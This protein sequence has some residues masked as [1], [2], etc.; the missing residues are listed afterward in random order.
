MLRLATHF[1]PLSFS[2]Y[3]GYLQSGFIPG[4]VLGA[5][6][7]QSWSWARRGRSQAARTLCLAVG[8]AVTFVYLSAAMWRGWQFKSQPVGVGIGN[9]NNM[10]V[11]PRWAFE[12]FHLSTS[13][14]LPFLLS[15]LMMVVSV[16]WT[17]SRG[18]L[19][20]ERL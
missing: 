9:P 15:V 4:A 7:A 16:A 5:G 20:K 13:K 14:H 1:Q 11:L 17:A 10:V 12:I 3:V 19:Q 6:T 2:K 8:S 18:D